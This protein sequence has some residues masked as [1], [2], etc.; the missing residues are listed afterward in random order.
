[1]TDA[2]QLPKRDDNVRTL[3]ATALF[4]GNQL[5]VARLGEIIR[6]EGDLQAGYDGRLWRYRTGVFR[7]DGDQWARSRVREILGDLVQRRHF[8]EILAWL[9][10]FPPTIGDTP[11][12]KYLNVANGMLD[13]RNGHLTP[14]NPA[15]RST[16]QLP[17]RWN[18]DASCPRVEIFLAEVLLADTID[19]AWE[20]IGYALYTGN[21]MRKAVLLL[22]GGGNGKSTFLAL[23]RSLC[24]QRNCANVALQ[25]LGENRFAAAELYGKVANIC[26]DLDARS[27]RRTDLF[28]QLTGGD[29]IFA[30]RKNAHPFSFTSYALPIFSANEPPI[31][32]DQTEA[33]FDRWLIVPMDARIEGT[34][35]CDTDLFSKLAT[36]EE[37]E[38]AL[39]LAVKGLQRLMARG[40][41]QPPPTV[42]Q[43]GE[44]Y[45]DRLDSARG[46]LAEMCII[47]PEAWTA[48]PVLYKNYKAWCHDTTR[49]A[50]GD[51]RFNEHVSQV[52][53]TVI[54]LI[55]RNGIRGWKGIGLLTDRPDHP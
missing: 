43:A 39:V 1:M 41:F 21:P 53:P 55:I 32:A 9:R 47:H 42:D 28:K 38:G 29:P 51:V 54:S 35:R 13:W 48:R 11:G 20:V 40:R 33:W 24:G 34:P 16:V 37:L 23:I 8:D 27:I 19:F 12:T 52:N 49:L 36:D 17:I 45:R 6:N 50:V 44:R 30:E 4:N 22:G 10:S 26:G 5:V 46:F 18:S 31:S 2:Q 25:L 14:H 3:P 15:A 7:P